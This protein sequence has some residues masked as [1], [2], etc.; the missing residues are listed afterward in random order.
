MRD[1]PWGDV[2]WDDPN[3]GKI[4]LRPSLPTLRWNLKPKGLKWDGVAF[5]NPPEEALS[6]LEEVE[7]ERE[8]QGVGLAESLAAGGSFGR[9][10]ANVTLIESIQAGTFPDPLP[11]HLFTLR[12]GK[13]AW[14]VEPE[15]KD[16][17]W[18]DW[19]DASIKEITRMSNLI[20]SI[21]GGRRQKRLTQKASRE[22]PKP[23]EGSPE[24]VV[25]S[26]NAIGWWMMNEQLLGEDLTIKRDNRLAARLRGALASLRK[27]S[28]RQVEGGTSGQV[29]LLTPVYLPWRDRM[30]DAL[31]QMPESEEI[32]PHEEGE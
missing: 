15:L 2:V 19:V 13:P 32:T 27:E 8:S 26:A 6:W 30:L 10:L 1:D 28:N 21:W 12:R 29:V 23:K 31:S 18:S 25:A 5:L 7:R 24:L 16:E 11:Y 14:F 20:K 4:L 22:L 9:Y 17:D 3:G